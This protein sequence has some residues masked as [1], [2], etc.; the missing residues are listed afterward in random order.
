MSKS[1]KGA[2]G[3]SVYVLVGPGGL[4][5]V[6]L[7]DNEADCWRVALGWPDEAEIQTRKAE[8][9][10]VHKA[11]VTWTAARAERERGE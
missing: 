7:H 1:D 8:G 9:Y 5:H 11:N 4:C 2:M 6:G 3:P 10:A